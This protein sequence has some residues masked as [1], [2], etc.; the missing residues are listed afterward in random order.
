MKEV[1][2][3][4]MLGLAVAMLFF[5]GIIYAWSIF[6]TFIGSAFPSY[7]ATNLSLNFSI[8]MIGFCLGGF[9]GGKISTKKNPAFAGRI[10]AFLLFLGFMGTSFMGGM[11]PY[12]ALIWMYVCYGLFAGVGTGMGYNVCVSNVAEWFPKRIGFISGVLLM[13]FGLG[14]FFIGL[15]VKQ[16]ANYIDFF[17]I[18]RILALVVFVL[19]FVGSSFIKKPEKKVFDSTDLEAESIAP[20]KMLMSSIFWMFFAWNVI[21][22]SAGLIIVN[23]AANISVYYGGLAGLGLL[24][25]LFNGA[26]RPLVGFIMDKFGQT[27]GMLIVNGMLLFASFMLLTTS[28]RHNLV[29]MSLG[30]FLIGICYG[31]G[32]TISAKFINNHFGPQYYSVNFSLANFCI[33]PASI[34]GP[35][36][37][38]ILLDYSGGDYRPTFI[39]LLIMVVCAMCLI[40]LLK[41]LTNRT[42][43]YNLVR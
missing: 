8:T 5:M 29:T 12:K 7:T 22:S 34:I 42:N 43:I 14:S 1:N 13:G 9:L 41:I 28:A 20:K 37:S 11:E 6:K 33:I 3:Q 40:F 15:I 17:V 23:S 30:M 35:Y 26:G 38:G 19:V 4:G 39:L 16:I 10:A 2:K 31:G 21:V 32:I 36:I 24:V 18:L 25:S 27:K